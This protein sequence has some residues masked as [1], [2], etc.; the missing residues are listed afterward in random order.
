[1]IQDPSRDNFNSE[2][3]LFLDKS[4]VLLSALDH[5]PDLEAHKPSS[6][7]WSFEDLLVPRDRDD[8]LRLSEQ[9]L[10]LGDC[11]K[12]HYDLRG[13][14]SPSWSLSGSALRL[15]CGGL[16]LKV[17]RRRGA[18]ERPRAPF[19]V[20]MIDALSANIAIVNSEGIIV[21][22][23]EAWRGFADSN[24]APH[25]SAWL[26]CS[27]FLGLGQGPQF[28]EVKE[29]L[30][31]VLRGE[32]ESFWH[33]YPCHSPREKRWFQ[34]R[35]TR[36]DHGPEPYFAICHENIT[37]LKK[38]T[39]KSLESA[40]LVDEIIKNVDATFWLF[41]FEQAE[42]QYVSP[43]FR[44]LKGSEPQSLFSSLESFFACVS[45]RD[46]ESLSTLRERWT[47]A[48]A[49]DFEF[50][51][52][53]DPERPRWFEL[54]AFPL[55]KNKRVTRRAGF[56]TDIT[57][58]KLLELEL[59]EQKTKLRLL[60]QR[61]LDIAQRERRQIAQNLHDQTAQKLSLMAIYSDLLGKHTDETGL[62][63]LTKLQAGLKESIHEVRTL[64][65]EICPPILY[66]LG[67]PA[68]LSWLLEQIQQR[69]S[70]QTRLVNPD[71]LPELPHSMKSIL[72]QVSRELLQ[73]VVKHA[74]ARSVEISLEVTPGEFC[75]LVS[76]DGQG[77]PASSPKQTKK[78]EGFGLFSI[79]EQL[80]NF[81]GQLQIESSEQKGTCARCVLPLPNNEESSL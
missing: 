52:G 50:S 42:F 60:T 26:G 63:I 58:R 73:N 12:F 67:L 16:L 55:F 69:E 22:V 17:R 31:A 65:F 19:A 18:K 78:L 81:G 39:A 8:F 25:E 35:V 32:R 29:G 33:E 27:Y 53:S 30:Q 36:I 45:N 2:T 77:F 66:S 38:A 62:E 57:R 15:P 24:E 61:T 20:Q 1:M 49:F 7:P 40:Q 54:R 21:E 76:D 6:K 59:Q 34:M 3:C 80:L 44:E 51:L 43:S 71:D 75:L 5:W 11:F 23:N 56:L 37:E 14:T 4:R 64:I 68:A 47:G 10:A 48:E 28:R 41:D 79:E 70:L 9:H 46:K 13:E 72:Y 74:Q